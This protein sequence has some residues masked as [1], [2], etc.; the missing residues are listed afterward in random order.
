MGVSFRTKLLNRMI[1]SF[2]DVRGYK[3]A[4]RAARTIFRCSKSWPREEKYALTDQIRPSSRSVFANVAEAWRK[5]RYPKHFISTLS[6]ADAEAAEARAWLDAT[7]DHGCIDESTHD[8]LDAT[9][10]QISGSPV[11]MMS[12][13]DRWCGPARSVEEES[14]PYDLGDDHSQTHTHPDAHTQR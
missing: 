12:T 7:P 2:R 14:I 9:C 13:P 3:N 11:K 1:E 8:D 5:R 10:N 6:D 4:F